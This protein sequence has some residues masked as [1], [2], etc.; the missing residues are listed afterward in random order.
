[1]RSTFFSCDEEEGLFP[2][3]EKCT[4]MHR[5]VDNGEGG[6]THNDI[7]YG[8]GGLEHRDSYSCNGRAS[9]KQSN[10]CFK[11]PA[12]GKIESARGMVVVQGG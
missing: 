4:E 7:D 2:D 6:F 10:G 3:L 8:N 11:A 1:M 9:L 12:V 5:C